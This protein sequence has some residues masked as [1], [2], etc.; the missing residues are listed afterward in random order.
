MKNLFYYL[1]HYGNL[2]FSQHPFNSVDSL[3][4]S[5]LAYIDF[6][7]FVGG[8]EN[9][10]SDCDLEFFSKQNFRML[11]KDT[12]AKRNNKKLIKLIKKS[13][14]FNTM[15]INYYVNHWNMQAEIQFSAITFI[16]EDFCYIAYRG[17][18]LT[19]VGWKEDFNMSFLETIPS[20]LESLSYLNKVASL[21]NKK[22]FIG[23]HSKGGN[24]A[25]YASL[26]CSQEIKNRIIKIFDHDGPGFKTNYYNSTQYN[27]IA[28]KLD[29]TIVKESLVG[30]AMHHIP[31][32]KVVDCY[33]VFLF[34]H[35]PFNWKVTKKGDFKYIFQNNK[36]SQIFEKFVKL[37]LEAFNEEQR[38]KFVNLAFDLM[39][40]DWQVNQLFLK[41][42]TFIRKAKKRFKMLDKESQ[43]FVLNSLRLIFQLWKECKTQYKQEHKKNK[44]PLNT[45]YE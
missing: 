36:V 2:N 23:G 12:L 21:I 45:N 32:Y 11:T 42:I 6:Q 27:E 44:I 41:S 26:F 9:L 35:D 30:V 18:D 7:D 4:L 15:K 3:I 28:F 5:Q 34:Q 8:I 1:K 37:W 33:G 16:F 31:D 29:K 24:L 19:F 40:K 20:H 10:Q 13:S 43:E 39:G 14:R 22:I 38:L 17:T 25:L